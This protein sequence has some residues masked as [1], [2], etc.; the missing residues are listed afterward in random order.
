GHGGEAPLIFCCLD[1]G[2]ITHAMRA[3]IRDRLAVSP[4]C[5]MHGSG[6]DE[7]RLVLTATHTHSAPGGCTHDALYNMPTPGFVPAH[8]AAVVD[9]A[10]AA[11]EAALAARAPTDVA[12]GEDSF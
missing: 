3:G 7:S 6:F 2:C 9:A 11:I 1:L 12:L 4:A 10:C 5:G 8:L